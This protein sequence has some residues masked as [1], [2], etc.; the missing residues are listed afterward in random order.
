MNE[1]KEMMA[2]EE[3]EE[4]EKEDEGGEEREK[5][6]EGGEERERGE[7]KERGVGGERGVGARAG[8]E[9][10]V[11]LPSETYFLNGVHIGT[12]QKTGDM[13]RFIYQTRPDGLYLLDVEKID[14]R[15]LIA[16]RFLANYEP[17]S[18]LVVSA[19]EYGHHPV[20]RFAE[21]TGAA[22]IVERFIPGTLTN[23]GSEYFREPAILVVT[24]PMTDAQA[25]LEG[26]STG[27]PILALCDTNNS[28][29]NVDFVI[30]T[31]NHG[32]KALATVYWLLARE[33][34]RERHRREGEEEEF[35]FGYSVE[36]FEA[37]I[38]E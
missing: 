37:E 4:R 27:I 16:A 22:S 20:S 38:Y 34:L 23:P 35:V 28:T 12:Q 6:D 3:G 18:V 17:S 36:D 32:R 19:R 11:L 9:K 13:K 25:L 1:D 30:P 24:D 33:V 26:V 29:A 5:E 15:L 2:E 10:T 31:N 21:A 7:K 14:A 8:T